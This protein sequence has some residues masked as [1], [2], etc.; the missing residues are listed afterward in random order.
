[1]QATLGA[2]DDPDVLRHTPPDPEVR[3]LRAV[4]AAHE[5]HGNREQADAARGALEW[6]KL[7][8]HVMRVAAEHK[9]STQAQCDLAAWA[10][11][12]AAHAPRIAVADAAP[13]IALFRGA[14][15]GLSHAG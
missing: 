6:H 8:T 15:G 2:P 13:L 4:T 5:R 9:P 11:E 12:H 1:M 14:P 7:E 10:A 3:R